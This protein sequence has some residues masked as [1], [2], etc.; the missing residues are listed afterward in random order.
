MS[1]D[2]PDLVETSTSMAKIRT[3]EEVFI[4]LASRS[5]SNTQ[6]EAL[7]DKIEAISVLAGADAERGQAY[8]GWLPNLNSKVLAIMKEGAIELWDKDPEIK[9]IHAGLECGIIGTNYPDM[10]M[11]SFGPN[12][13]GAH[14][15][16][17]KVQISSVQ[18]YWGYLMETLQRIPQK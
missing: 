8:P 1:P 9:A 15:P 6:L 14:S 12:I 5:S 18:K 16:D 11:I 7:R 3:E 17:E 10:Q 2:I 4:Q 13:R